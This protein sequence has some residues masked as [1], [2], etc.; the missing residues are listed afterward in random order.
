MSK[1]VRFRATVR[2]GRL[3]PARAGAGV[4]ELETDAENLARVTRGLLGRRVV[5]TLQPVEE[6]QRGLLE[7]DGR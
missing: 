6:R 5:V 7:E 3:L 2:D 4:L 1:S